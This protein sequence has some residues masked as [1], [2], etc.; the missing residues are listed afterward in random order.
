MLRTLISHWHKDVIK[1]RGGSLENY[2]M[3][4]AWNQVSRLIGFIIRTVVLLTWLAAEA[5][6]I[7]LTIAVFIIFILWPLLILLLLSLGLALLF[8]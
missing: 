1:Y 3:T 2:A 6:F 4:F 8:V 7:P 5:I